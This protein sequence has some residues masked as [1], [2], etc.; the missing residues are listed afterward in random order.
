MQPDIVQMITAAF[1]TVVGLFFIIWLIH[2][3][4]NNAGIVDVG[5]GIG[6]S[7]IALIYIAMAEGFNIR[8]TLM[9]T[10]VALWGARIA[11]FLIRRIIFEKYEDK[12]YG[13]LRHKWGDKAKFNFLWFFEAQAIMQILISIPI[14]IITLNPQTTIGIFEVLGFVI[15]MGSLYGEKISDDQLQSFKE[16]PDNKGKVCQDGLWGLSRHPNYFFEV[17][18][19]FGLFIFALGSPNGWLGIVAPAIM[20]YLILKVT[21]IPLTEELSLKHRGEQ[22]K[23]YQK[24]TRALIPLPRRTS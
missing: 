6:F 16:N 12:R 3:K 10:M 23:E 14:L 4:L 5:W 19:W 13:F 7:I 9:F 17:T 11:L 24:N 20:L 8:N 22:Y 1:F 18:C 15:W 2:L 21:G